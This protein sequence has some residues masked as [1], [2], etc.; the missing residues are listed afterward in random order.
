MTTYRLIC[1]GNKKLKDKSRNH[2]LITGRSL[3][4]HKL[5]GSGKNIGQIIPI[6]ITVPFWNS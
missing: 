4:G 5:L 3:R 1:V 2:C 6:T